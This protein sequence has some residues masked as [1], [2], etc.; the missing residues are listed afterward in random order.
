MTRED[1][2]EVEVVERLAHA[3]EYR[4][5]QT[6][7]HPQRVGR[8]S[9]RIAIALGSDSLD[10]VILRSAAMLHDI[11]KV[12]VPD[13]VLLKT[14]KLSREEFE[15][16]KR[17]TTIGAQML[18]GSNLPLLQMAKEIALSH[19]ER[20]DGKGYP[21]GLAGNDI[22]L[23]GRIVAVADFLDALTHDRPYRKAFSM[24]MT[25]ELVKG[26]LGRQFD[27]DVV[28]AFLSVGATHLATT[29]ERV[30]DATPP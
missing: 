5:D 22:P 3:C 11:G 24:D 7:E 4:E 14:D 17:H 2:P 16:L 19:H 30:T 29:V 20:W 8:L 6:G 25:L 28:E 15:V 21:L 1:V 9:A 26:D 23:S 18:S 13:S 10:A 27:P 12:A